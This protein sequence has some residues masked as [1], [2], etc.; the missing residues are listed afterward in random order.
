MRSS[1]SLRSRRLKIAQRFIAGSKVTHQPSPVGTA[2]AGISIQI[3]AVPTGL[4]FC[5]STIPSDKSLG[6]FR[7]V[8][9]GTI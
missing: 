2:E 7:A 8:P 4:G 3:S 5:C 6:Y 1:F 9:D